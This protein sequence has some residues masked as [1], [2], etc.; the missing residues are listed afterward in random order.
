M[1]ARTQRAHGHQQGKRES[2]GVFYR[3][4]EVSCRFVWAECGGADCRSL[5]GLVALIVSPPLRRFEGRVASSVSI[6][7]RERNRLS[8]DQADIVVQGGNESAAPD[9]IRRNLAIPW[10]GFIN[11]R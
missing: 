4:A 2:G 7:K 5:R 9:G 8:G 3:R 1:V 6:R 10:R 11:R